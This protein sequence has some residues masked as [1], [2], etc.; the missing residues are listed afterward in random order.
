M[1]MI[2]YSVKR[3]FIFI[4][5]SGVKY[6]CVLDELESLGFGQDSNALLEAISLTVP[7]TCEPH[8]YLLLR[9]CT[10]PGKPVM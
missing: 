2:C 4:V 5:F 6:Y 3:L 1:A 8:S 7:K 9:A 10:T